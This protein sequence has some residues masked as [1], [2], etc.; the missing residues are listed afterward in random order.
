MHK[1]IFNISAKIPTLPECVKLAPNNGYTDS[2]I[3]DFDY[4]G[5][6][7]VSVSFANACGQ[8]FTVPS[9]TIFT[10]TEN[11]GNLE[12]KI[13]SFTIG[14][15]QTV[16]IP[17]RYYGIMKADSLTKNFIFT[18]NGTSSSFTLNI[19]HPVVTHPPV[20]QTIDMVLE[21]RTNKT[22]SLADFTPYY[23]DVDGHAL[24]AVLLTGDL[25]R[26]R[27]NGQ[28]ITSP[29]EIDV[30]DIDNGGFVYLAPDTNDEYNV[31]IQLRVRDASGE[32]SIL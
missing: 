10:D 27:L 4:T 25:S 7:G 5:E 14:A 26:F 9:F 23:S 29:A 19:T 22:F 12:V 8:P 1:I 3:K 28:A 16:N 31:I 15:G 2:V 21:N 32:L 17:V 24:D 11:G 30:Y 18:F 13:N 6:T 20:I